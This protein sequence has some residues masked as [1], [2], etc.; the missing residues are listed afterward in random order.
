MYVK[1][2]V[3]YGLIFSALVYFIFPQINLFGALIIFSSSIL[4]DFDHYLIYV[5]RKKDLSIK[6]AYW[7]CRYLGDKYRNLPKK[8][9]EKVHTPLAWFHSIEA[10]I[11]INLISLIFPIFWFV[12]IGM[13]FHIATDRSYAIYRSF[14]HPN[15]GAWRHPLIPSYRFIK[16]KGFT[17]IDNVRT[18]R[19]KKSRN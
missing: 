11:I 4:I 3:F 15:R 18:K 1:Y 7:Y 16:T 13:V 2:H 10:L 12:F 5:F 19:A 6:K 8:T 14:K 9:A 17:D